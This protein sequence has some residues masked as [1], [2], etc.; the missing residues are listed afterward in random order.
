MPAL[1]HGHFRNRKQSPEYRSWRSMLNRCYREKNANY[2]HYGGR[3]IMVCERWRSSFS[4]FL[5]DM[6]S[7]PDRH[8]LERVDCNG[9]YNPGNCV[10]VDLSRQSRNTR[11]NRMLTYRGVTKCMADWADIT[12]ERGISYTTLRR[13]LRL[14]WSVE[15]AMTQ[16]VGAVA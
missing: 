6:G 12:Q 2:K 14:G 11:A 15:R 4:E 3:G 7:R 1:S 10:W 9:N 13:R 16:P 8:S 5:S